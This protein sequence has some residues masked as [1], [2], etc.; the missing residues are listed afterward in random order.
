[1]VTEGY[2]N[3]GPGSS[4]QLLHAKVT[5]FRSAALMGTLDLL[6]SR[7]LW[8]SCSVRVNTRLG[9]E[10]RA[11][12]SALMFCGRVSETC[13]IGNDN[14][15]KPTHAKLTVAQRLKWLTGTG[16]ASQQTHGGDTEHLARASETSLLR[17]IL[18]TAYVR[19]SSQLRAVGCLSLTAAS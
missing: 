4:S 3:D 17:R 1:M 8:C 13:G 12:Q 19:R 11:T 5:F 15:N 6:R 10:A 18:R 16:S 14:A 2:D 9:T 7:P